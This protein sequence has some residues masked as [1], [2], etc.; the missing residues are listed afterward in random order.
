MCSSLELLLTLIINCNSF[1]KT[2][3]LK[4]SLI[5]FYYS[6]TKMNGLQAK[7]LY[8]CISR[9]PIMHCNGHG[10]KN[11]DSPSDVVSALAA[12]PCALIIFCEYLPVLFAYLM[13][14]RHR[15]RLLV[16]LR[17]SGISNDAIFL[18]LLPFVNDSCIRARSCSSSPEVRRS[19]QR[20]R[21]LLST[22]FPD[23]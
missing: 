7:A 21:C 8:S 22:H 5:N 19:A 17:S 23:R 4:L 9:P 3:R 6:Q 2:T 14:I 11:P 12:A 15:R 18:R 10:L 20:L 13:C 1:Y 16:G